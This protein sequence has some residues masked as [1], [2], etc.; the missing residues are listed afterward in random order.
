MKRINS[1]FQYISK[2]SISYFDYH[3]KNYLEF[4]I[5]KGQMSIWRPIKAPGHTIV[6]AIFT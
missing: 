6:N 4:L 5:P 3:S 1:L 2:Y